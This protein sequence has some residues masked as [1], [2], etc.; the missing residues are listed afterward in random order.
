MF[1]Q[2]FLSPGYFLVVALTTSFT[3]SAQLT[4]DGIADKGIYNDTVSYRVQ[5]QSG[6]TYSAF[7]NGQA[8]VVGVFHTITRPDYYELFVQRTETATSIV[9]NRLVRFLVNASERVD[10]EWGLPPH[11]PSP[12][13]Q[14]SSNELAG[15]H[16]QLLAPQ[17]F[18]V[19]YEIPI[20]AWVRN[21]DGH[22]VRANGLLTAPGHPVIQLRRG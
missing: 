21:D 5:V 20:V 17:A 14:A 11:T 4:I 16:L 13:I 10:T 12:L 15:A 7:L 22:A 8:V 9:T 18:P 1:H 6:F 19:G 2:K 3:A